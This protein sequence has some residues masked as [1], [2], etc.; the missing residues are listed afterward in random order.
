MLRKPTVF[1]IGAGASREFNMPV[2]TGLRD[3]I[4]KDVR[5]RFD[6]PGQPSSGSGSLLDVLRKIAPGS[7]NEYTQAGNILAE[8]MPP[9]PS[10]DEALHYFSGNNRVVE[11]GKLAIAHQIVEAEHSSHL[12]A[13]NN[14]EAMGAFRPSAHNTWLFQLLSMVLAGTE[15]KADRPIFENLTIINFN[16]DRIVEHFL[17]LALQRVGSRHQDAAA[18]AVSRLKMLRPYGSIGRLRWQSASDGISFGVQSTLGT[19]AAA[20]N[21]RTF[22]E[23]FDDAALKKQM[24]SELERAHAIFF[25]GF[26]YH[27]QNMRL[28]GLPA[29]VSRRIPVM[30]TKFQIHRANDEA[31][32]RGIASSMRTKLEAVE[33]VDMTAVE[34]MEQLRPSIVDLVG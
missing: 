31:L 19:I 8:A 32:K 7:V 29:S 26:G 4:A 3:L 12:P 2:G 13:E 16:Y 1:I 28:L 21:I 34:F 30:A 17:Y 18:D 20:A 23:Q 11:L 25:V 5:F 33:L 22:T 14:L 10:I 9:F 15:L 27:Q 24:T 6:Y